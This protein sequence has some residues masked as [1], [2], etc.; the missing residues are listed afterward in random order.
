MLT[1]HFAWMVLG[2]L[3]AGCASSPPLPPGADKAP[4]KLAPAYQMESH[5]PGEQGMVHLQVF[6]DENG[7]PVKLFVIKSSGFP[8]LDQLAVDAVRNW[9][10]PPA[11]LKGK[12]SAEWVLVP[13]RFVYRP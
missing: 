6:A 13:I 4:E 11:K 1:K 12:P 10:F 5:R 9:R 7:K 2:V 3:L 8:R